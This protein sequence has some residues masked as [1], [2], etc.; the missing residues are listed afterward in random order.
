M[1][2]ND[3]ENIK[4]R[5]HD[6]FGIPDF[7]QLTAGSAG[8]DGDY[9]LG[10]RYPARTVSLDVVLMAP[11]LALLQN[12][13][14]VVIERLNPTVYSGTLKFSQANGT[15][16]WFDC[17]LAE[18]LPMPTIQHVG[19]VA[20]MLTLRFRSVRGPFLYDPTLQ[21]VPVASG[22]NLSSGT[23]MSGGFEFP[24]LLSQSGEFESATLTYDG[25][26]PTPVEL[27]LYGPAIEPVFR[28]ETLDR[29]VGFGGS[30]LNLPQ[31][32]LLTVNM[33]PRERDVVFQGFNGWPYLRESEFWWLQPGPNSLSFE[34][35]G[36][37]ENTL[38]LMRYYRRY[39]GV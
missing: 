25:H 10:V 20:M 14:E 37:D 13:R 27:M 6:G 23:F 7:S 17:V 12:L 39:L 38:L 33:D 15:V 9:W 35:G 32:G 2:L 31:G 16:R 26:V 3:G 34:V 24:F 18:S 21:E 30:G 29:V 22:S 5:H 4:L 28:N 11:G 36:T 1:N 8:V 19:G